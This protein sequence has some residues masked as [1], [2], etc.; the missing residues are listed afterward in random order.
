M[1]VRITEFLFQIGIQEVNHSPIELCACIA[2]AQGMVHPGEYHHVEEMSF[3]AEL[4]S[5]FQCVVEMHIVVAGAAHD[6]K[7]TFQTVASSDG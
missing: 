2:R 1:S 6:E 7:S 5:I 4:R 3:I